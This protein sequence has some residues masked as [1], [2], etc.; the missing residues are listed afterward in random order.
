MSAGDTARENYK[1][2]R[3]EL[4]AHIQIRDNVLFI[5]LGAIGALFGLALG[6]SA[7]PD[8]LLI[9]PL[10][11]VGAAF[12]VAQHD[13][14][15]GALSS[16]LIDEIEPFLIEIGESAPQ[17]DNSSALKEYS[18]RSV[19]F[20]TAGHMVFLEAPSVMAL[21]MNWKAFN[22]PF[23]KGPLWWLGVV[24]TGFAMYILLNNHTWRKSLKG[25]VAWRNTT[26]E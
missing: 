24:F 17:W 1:S 12:I 19:S 6:S 18:S 7:R 5:Y 21:G 15:I 26:T 9:I 16:F 25:R 10:L 3:D 4:I 13:G 20:R 2:A 23:P 8:L 14:L 11:S 22:F